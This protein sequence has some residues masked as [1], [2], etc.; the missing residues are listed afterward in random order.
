MGYGSGAMTWVITRTSDTT[1][2]I[3]AT[4]RSGGIFTRDVTVSSGAPSRIEFYAQN[5][6]RRTVTTVS[7]TS[8]I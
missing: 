4:S 2:R 8:T 5:S 7:L 1:L 6:R 3:T